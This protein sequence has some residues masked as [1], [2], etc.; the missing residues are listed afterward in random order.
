MDW[1]KASFDDAVILQE[2]SVNNDF[3]ANNYS[4]VNSIL[5]SGKFSS[6]I[7]TEK[8]WIYEKF[9]SGGKTFFTFPHNVS[10]DNSAL[11][12][13]LSYLFKENPQPN[14]LFSFN[15]ITLS[16]KNFLQEHFENIKIIEE[17]GL[18]D[19]VYLSEKLASL[20]GKKYSRKRNHIHQFEKKYPDFKFEPLSES[21]LHIAGEIEEEWF[22]ET[23]KNI[24]ETEDSSYLEGLKIEKKII[25]SALKNF[26]YLKEACSMSGG[27][28]FAGGKAFSFCIS[29]LLGQSVTD[30]HFEKCLQD[31]AKDGGYAVINNEFAKTVTTKYINREEDL[32]IEGLR[33]AKLSY[34]PE[35]ILPKFSVEIKL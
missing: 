11:I 13:A 30:I 5:Y 15:N 32:G 3:F 27:I 9:S 16:E 12:E 25:S 20:S 6:Q 31:F 10:G 18:S 26:S 21:N 34:F 17:R 4:T 29:S 1:R 14:G 24:S 23:E 22:S 2:T 33:K 28:L 19:Y 8:G 35:I 7:S